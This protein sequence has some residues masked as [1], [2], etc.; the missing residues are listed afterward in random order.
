METRRLFLQ[1]TGLIALGTMLSPALLDA[2]AKVKNVGIQLYSLRDV[3]QKDT[4]NVMTALAKFGYKEIESYGID[5]GNFHGIAAKE[6]KKMV[7]DL[8][9]KLISAHAMPGRLAD[10]SVKESIDVFA[11]KWKATVETANQAGLKYITVPYMEDNFRQSLDDYKQSVEALNKLGEYASSQGLKCT[12]HNHA[13]EFEQ[14]E[15][16]DLYEMM[17]TGCDAKYVNF[18]MDLYWVVFAGKDP[19]TY[20][21]KYPKRF[22]QWHV[23]DMSKIKREEN[24]DLGQG[25]ID[26]TKIFQKA[27]QAGTKHFFVE[28]ETGY[29]P[30]SITSVGNGFKYLKNMNY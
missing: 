19:L 16:Q 4:K 25:A 18:E 13:F 14:K 6:F 27:K 11:P 1:K 3:I 10:K 12:Y 2:T 26:F 5:S 20:F 30:D 9:M 29:N 23:K 7:E 15:G 17:L 28:Q 24:A 8:G 21:E 22:F